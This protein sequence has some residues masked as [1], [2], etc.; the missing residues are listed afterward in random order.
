MPAHKTAADPGAGPA[1]TPEDETPKS[2]RDLMS[3]RLLKAA[4]YCTKPTYVSFLRAHKITAV[5]WRLM[6]NLYADAPM[7]LAR[8]AMEV[9][10]QLAQASRTISSLVARGL[11]RGEADKRDGRS[12]QLSLTPAGRTL[13]RR[14]FGEA[15][16]RQER[17]LAS[18]TRNEKQ[19]LFRALEKLAVAGRAVYD[20][21]LSRP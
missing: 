11:V 13:Y 14:L 15:V 16:R 18:L 1:T 2:M 10:I 7:P 9:D 19:V 5:E 21:E 4:Y 20:E 12:V 6:G 17:Q 8:L 3:Y